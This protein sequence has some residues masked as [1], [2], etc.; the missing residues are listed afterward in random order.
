MVIRKGGCILNT[1][2]FAECENTEDDKIR[3][4]GSKQK[5]EEL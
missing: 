4:A 3:K 5:R 2:L 1:K